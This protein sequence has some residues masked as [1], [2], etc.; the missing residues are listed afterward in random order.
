LIRD[1]FN[2]PDYLSAKKYIDDV[3]LNQDVWLAVSEWTKNR[4]HNMQPLRILE[5]G[6]GI[7]TMIERLLETGL[8]RECVYSAIEL[9]P[10]FRDLAFER[11]ASWSDSNNY[12]LKE[13]TSEKRILTR[14]ENRIEIEWL[15]GD[16]LKMQDSLINNSYDLLLGH[17]IV[18]LLPVPV[19]MPGLLACLTPGGAYYFSL[20]FAGQTIFL[21]AHPSDQII[22]D[23]YHQDMDK[24]F[25]GLDWRPSQTGLSLGAWLNAEGH[26]LI[27]DGPSDWYLPVEFL[28]KDINLL[29]IANILDTIANALKGLPE[30]NEWLETRRRQLDA[31]DLKLIVTNRDCFGTVSNDSD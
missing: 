15:T 6:A 19:C 27:V 4:Q 2:Y 7:G 14:N 30:L 31:G 28:K 11:L 21:P 16:I 8:L 25:P 5:I 1:T 13:I 12:S 9:E 22:A 10:A 26:T 29:F 17:A 3:S 18:D 20:N 24:R 23:S